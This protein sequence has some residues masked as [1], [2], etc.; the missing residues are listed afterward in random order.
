MA[1]GAEYVN[2]GASQLRLQIRF[3]RVATLGRAVPL[4]LGVT[5]CV[6]VPAA[7]V[8]RR[9]VPG[10]RCLGCFVVLS[11]VRRLAAV[12]VCGVAAGLTALGLT[13]DE[14]PVIRPIPRTARQFRGRSVGDNGSGGWRRTDGVVRHGGNRVVRRR[15]RSAVHRR[16]GIRGRRRRRFV[17][18]RGRRRTGSRSRACRGSDFVC[19]VQVGSS[20]GCR[21]DDAVG[22]HD[23]GPD[24]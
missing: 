1:G 9:D 14:L 21:L 20:T 19:H 6:A 18:P 17:G 16:S 12:R 2:S 5:V 8:G 24:P 7:R 13:R 15:T 3:K 22:R 4:A 11:G 10:R 23:R